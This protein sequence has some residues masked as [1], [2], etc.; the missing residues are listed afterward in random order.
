MRAHRFFAPLLA[1]ALLATGVAW[2]DAAADFAAGDAAYRRGDV[3]AAIANLRKAADAGHVRAQVLLGFIL[4]GAEEN[5]EAARYLAMADQQGDAEGTHMLAGLHAAGE[6]VPRDPARAREL[7]EKAAASGF[8]DS[9]LVMAGACLK[10]GLGLSDA[11][12]SSPAALA[13]IQKAADLGDLPSVDRLAIAYRKGEFG[14][15]PDEQMAK[16]YEARS[17]ALRGIDEKKAAPR[18][19]APAPRPPG[20]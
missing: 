10:G 15:S 8:R 18:R 3:R 6:G 11:E 5:A 16:Q 19:R 9:V 14:L 1:A 17:R 20:S 7:Y 12:R 4:D 2:A 13:W